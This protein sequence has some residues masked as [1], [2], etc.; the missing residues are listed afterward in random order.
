[1]N[2]AS[3]KSR[4][5]PRTTGPGLTIGV[6]IQPDLLADL[7]KYIASEPDP[8]PSRPDAIRR[9]LHD[10]LVRMGIRKP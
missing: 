6:R 2:N 3:A 7:D 10:E 8:K 4:G 5:R 1:M 9:L